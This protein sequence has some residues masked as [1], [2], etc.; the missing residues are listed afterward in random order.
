MFA[1]VAGCMIGLL[2]LDIRFQANDA[3]VVLHPLETMY[4]WGAAANPQL[5]A[6]GSLFGAAGVQ[7]LLQAIAGV[8]ARRTFILQSSPRPAIFLEWFVIAAFIIAVRRR[9]WR[10]VAEVAALMLTDWGIDLLGMGRHL[11]QAYFL[12]TDPLAI[13]AAA[14]L[15]ARL[16]D[17]QQHRWTYPLG[18]TLIAA[19]L[20]VSQAEPVKHIFKRA[21]PE[22]LCQGGLQYYYHRLGV[23]P[24]CQPQPAPPK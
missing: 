3:I 13:I 12:Y 6:G 17:L 18:V 19:T 11:Q 7:F 23:L 15:I 8:I 1:V 4:A 22:V 24:F 9:E 16:T 2:A 5:S 20:I 21:G 10:L 14:L